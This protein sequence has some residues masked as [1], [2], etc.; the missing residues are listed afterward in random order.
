MPETLRTERLLLR[1]PRDEDVPALLQLLT[2]PQVAQWW[3]GYDEA[4]VRA[5]FLAPPADVTVWALEHGG[6]VIG[7]IQVSEELEPDYRHAGLDIFMGT[8]WHGRGLS[9][10]AIRAVVGYL[11]AGRGHHR[12]V[13]DPAADNVRAIRAYARVGFRPVGVL[14]QY[15]RGPDGR[16]HDGLLME[17]LAD[18]HHQSLPRASNG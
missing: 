15:E 4:R 2:E 6:T 13:I 12:L 14:R 16:W 9:S 1:T 18:E 7:A 8:A 3:H 5:D 10:E 17:L 11:F